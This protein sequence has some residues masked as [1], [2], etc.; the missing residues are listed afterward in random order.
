MT[1]VGDGD[2]QAEPTGVGFG[3]DGVVE[4]LCVFAVDGDQGQL[5]QVNA[6]VCFEGVDFLAP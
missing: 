2:D 5:A 3:V 1:D 4:V 6:G